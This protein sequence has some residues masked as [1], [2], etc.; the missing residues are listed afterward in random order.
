[1]VP[2]VVVVL[3]C[4]AASSC[5]VS[6]RGTVTVPRSHP[7]ACMDSLGRWVGSVGMRRIFIGSSWEAARQVD[8]LA[9]EL[10]KTLGEATQIVEWSAAFGPGDV[11]IDVLE[12]EAR[13]ISGA[14][15]LAT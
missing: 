3:V 6:T 8:T 4:I 13:R 2:A 1:M 12:N 5:G 9:T 15:L 10:R 11:T 14:I 7:T